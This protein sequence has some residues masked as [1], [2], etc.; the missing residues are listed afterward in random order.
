M[1]VQKFEMNETTD[2]L[3]ENVEDKHKS[4]DDNLTSEAD[5]DFENIVLKTNDIFKYSLNITIVYPWGSLKPGFHSLEWTERP[6][7]MRRC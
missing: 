4:L 6:T 7:G 5:S 3:E 2:D 1:E